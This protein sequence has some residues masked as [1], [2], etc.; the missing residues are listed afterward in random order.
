MSLKRKILT[1]RKME[2]L[3][4]LWQAKD[5]LCSWS[6][7]PVLLQLILTYESLS[8]LLY[9]DTDTLLSTRALGGAEGFRVEIQSGQF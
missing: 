6:E 2:D 7:T 4:I 8:T 9:S 1:E 3:A 5:E